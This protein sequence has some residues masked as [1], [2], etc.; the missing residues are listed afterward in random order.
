MGTGRKMLV[1]GGERPRFDRLAAEIPVD[2]LFLLSPPTDATGREVQ[3]EQVAALIAMVPL[4][5]G[6]NLVAAVTIVASLWTDVPHWQLVAW[7]A[8]FAGLCSQRLFRAWRLRHDPAYAARKPSSVHT[9][10]P[11]ILMLS[12]LWAVPASVW[13]GMSGDEDKI[14]IALM[15][16]GLASGASVT[17]STVPPAAL[18]YV[19]IVSTA[20][21]GALIL[22]GYVLLIGL[23]LLFGGALA[24]T[25][26]W[27][28]RQFVGHLRA[29]LEVEEQAAM[30]AL[31]RQFEASGS[32]WLWEL[33][34]NLCM[35][36]MSSAFIN[37]SG[38]PVER[39]IGG[40]VRQL[41]DPRGDARS[42]SRGMRQLFDALAEGNAFRE[43]A[44]PVRGGRSWWIFSGQPLLGPD[45]K[46]TG[47]RGVGSDVTRS[48]RTGRNSIR[49]A[50]HDPLTGLPNRLLIRELI[51]ES[52]L[53]ER[54]GRGGCALLLLDLDRFKL[55]NDTLGHALGD[56]LLAAAAGRLAL[57]VGDAE[58]GRLGGDEFAIV[59]SGMTDRSDVS[60]LAERVI[61]ALSQPF[62]VGSAD[63]TIGATVGI[64]LAPDDGMTEGTLTRNADLALYSAKAAGRG[65]CHFFE[66]AMAER[67]KAQRELERDL[68]VALQSGELSL[69]Y[70]PIVEAGSHRIVGREALLRWSHP[71]RGDIPP[72]LFIPVIED[73][74]LISQVGNWVVR[75]A[76]REAASWKDEARLAVNVSAVQLTGGDLVGTVVNALAVSGLAPER[77][78]LEVTES[79]FLA[80]DEATRHTLA[81]LRAV[82][83]QL[84]L[85]DFG[86]GYSSLK[87][88]ARGEFSKIKIDRSFV[89]G[90]GEGRS[91][92]RAIVEA[93]IAL[94]R[95]M[96][97]DVTAEGIE[98]A[99]QALLFEK[100]GCDQLQGFHF[101]RPLAADQHVLVL[102]DLPSGSQRRRIARA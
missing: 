75:E 65:R 9:I 50:R 72:D 78:E 79:V 29:R 40:D 3:V 94:G 100:M 14:L 37:S 20:A 87:S 45:G 53:Q 15:L 63:L 69:A 85:D 57:V 59:A 12:V 102:P 91:D 47:W 60:A 28:A 74:G 86:M 62:A 5:V 76:C 18:T 19:L 97:C 83:I 81:R 8:L 70:Q 61:A 96:R 48:R 25:I 43:I 32:D 41:L 73:T 11:P 6:A 21:I 17:L 30:I 49:A 89:A 10:M 77:L 34:P 24:Y 95:A 84:V 1:N 92:A 7:L 13:F 39:L 26:I 67:A 80:D 66:P 36:H 56:Q 42:V 16:F 93:V 31:L 51:E 38:Q 2:Q 88:L 27:N 46:I 35:R 82:G 99:A 52:L 71:E 101:G 64:A 68:R 55:V 90:A 98:T 58:V 23:V 54:S 33:D 44:V 22:A 4:T